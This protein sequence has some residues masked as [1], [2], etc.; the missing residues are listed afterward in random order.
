[1]FEFD[2]MWGDYRAAEWQLTSQEILSQRVSL[3][4]DCNTVNQ[5]KIR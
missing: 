1:M 2:R 3:S 5:N 4:L